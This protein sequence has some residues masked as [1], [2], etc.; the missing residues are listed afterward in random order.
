MGRNGNGEQNGRR[1]GRR[2]PRALNAEEAERL[3]AQVNP[4]SVTGL[5]NLVALLLMLRLGLRVSEV[6]NLQGVDLDLRGR[7]LHVVGKGQKDRLLYIDLQTATAMAL[8]LERRP[9]HSRA[10][11]TIIQSGRRGDGQAKAGQPI[12]VRYL[13]ELVT[14]LGQV[15][16]IEGVHCHL[17]RHTYACAELRRGV[18]IHQLQADLG[19][20]DLQTTAIYLHV[21]DPE[22][23]ESANG[24]PAMALPEAIGE[25]EPEPEP[26][27]PEA[28]ILMHL[29]WQPRDD[30][31]WMPPAVATQ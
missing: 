7:R 9:K 26:A 25:P 21:V 4:K 8:W 27:S 29:G 24:R 30:G 18:P 17:L 13:Q 22:R 6:V 14:R 3:L 11:L 28:A 1:R 31:S 19:H 10:L 16:G 15:A 5:R 23:E 2:L 12:S 20:S